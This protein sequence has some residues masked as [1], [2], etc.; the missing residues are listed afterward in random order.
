MDV[1]LSPLIHLAKSR[2]SHMGSK[3]KR[4]DRSHNSQWFGGDCG[5][6]CSGVMPVKLRFARIILAQCKGHAPRPSMGI[7]PTFEPLR[8]TG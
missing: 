8:G 2:T 5:G 1:S 3:K 6:A 7:V 4:E